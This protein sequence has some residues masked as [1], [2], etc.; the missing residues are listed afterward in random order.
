MRGIISAPI[1]LQGST[2]VR[3]RDKCLVCQGREVRVQKLWE[4][5]V[6]LVAY[7]MVEVLMMRK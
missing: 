3:I 6:G 2:E 7:F 4:W 5:L 1:V